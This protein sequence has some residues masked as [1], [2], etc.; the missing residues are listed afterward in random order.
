MEG[1]RDQREREYGQQVANMDK[2][3]LVGEGRRARRGRQLVTATAVRAPGNMLPGR[4]GPRA[5]AP[6]A[7]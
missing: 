4:A 1:A 5:G 2:E 7:C 3:Q 6:R